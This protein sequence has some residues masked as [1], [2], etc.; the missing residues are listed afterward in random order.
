M[1]KANYHTAPVSPND[2]MAIDALFKRIAE[3]G[4]KIRNQIKSI[5]T[6]NHGRE[7]ALVVQ[8]Q[9]KEQSQPTDEK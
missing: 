4:R 1:L 3:R 7:S 5:Q 6:T 9:Y 8:A 2:I